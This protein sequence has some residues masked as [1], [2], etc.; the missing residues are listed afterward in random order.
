MTSHFACFRAALLAALCLTSACTLGA[1][2]VDNAPGNEPTDGVVDPDNPNDPD[3]PGSPGNPGNPGAPVAGEPPELAGITAAHNATRADVGQAPLQWSNELATLGAGFI[4]DCVWGHSSGGE[5]TN[6]AGFGYVGENLYM[7]GGG[8]VSGAGVNGAWAS[9][10][11][12]Y[13]P[14]T[15][16]CQGGVCG[17]YT[18]QVWSTTTH[19]GCAA[20][21]CP[22]GSTIVV[23]EYGPGGNYSGQPAY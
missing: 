21:T 17:D 2:D 3:N 7:S 23:C 15:G 4:A 6:K 12:N 9:E 18:Q 16:Q 22:N 10:K 5:R 8:Q 20:K 1:I 13:N 14:S 19:V 11:P